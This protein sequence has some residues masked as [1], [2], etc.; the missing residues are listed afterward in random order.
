MG[1]IIGAIF[2]ANTTQMG[3]SGSTEPWPGRC[4][5]PARTISASCPSA[6]MIADSVRNC[7]TDAMQAGEAG[8]R[9]AALDGVCL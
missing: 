4:V 5:R 9:N 7:A 3:L 6:C 1:P 2:S 8:S